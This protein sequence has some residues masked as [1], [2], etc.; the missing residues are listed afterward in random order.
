[1][2]PNPRRVVYDCNI[3]V[4]AL[5]NRNG[6]AGRCVTHALDGDVTLFLSHQVLAEIRDAPS[7]PTP[8]RLGVTSKRVEILVE[9]LLAVSRTILDAPTVF[10]YDRDPHD[11]HYINLALAANAELVVSRDRDLLDLMDPARLEALAFQ[12][13]FPS[14][15]ILDPVHFLRELDA[16][17]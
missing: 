13:Q 7:K 17:E 1:M 11:A 14:L 5:I 2:N 10:S 9:R 12:H 8:A 4:Q 6:P 16:S 15:R 3:F